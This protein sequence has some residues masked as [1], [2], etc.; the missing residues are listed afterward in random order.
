MVRLINL[1]LL[2]VAFVLVS[3][4]FNVVAGNAGKEGS[5][6]FEVEAYGRRNYGYRQGSLRAGQCPSACSYRCSRTSKRKACMFFCQKCCATCL[7]VP[8][9]TYGNKEVCPCY[10]NWKTQEG[11]PKCP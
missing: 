6:A 2:C 8:P 4:C 5:D 10:N 3:V 9:G 1:L 11:G 7:C